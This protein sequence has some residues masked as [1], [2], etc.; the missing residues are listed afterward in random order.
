[1]LLNW[2]GSKSMCLMT[3]Q[4]FIAKE[5][6]KKSALHEHPVRRWIDKGPIPGCRVGTRYYMDYTAYLANGDPLVEKVLR[7]ESGSA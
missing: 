4:E 7:D 1:M 3:S 5:F 2:W 6:S